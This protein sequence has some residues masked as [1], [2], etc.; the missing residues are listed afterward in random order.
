MKSTE[1]LL[2][3]EGGSDLDKETRDMIAK[4][5]EACDVCKTHS[6]TPRRFKLTIGADDLRFNHCVQ[7]DTMFIQNLPIMHMVDAATQFRAASFPRSNAIRDIWKTIL[8]QW[9]F[10]YA[11]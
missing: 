6:A 8:A 3:R 5:G 1:I 11:G 4:I 10:L 7:I 2:R 9:S